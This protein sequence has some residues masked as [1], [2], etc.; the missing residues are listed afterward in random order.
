VQ[1]TAPQLLFVS[2]LNSVRLEVTVEVV[3]VVEVVAVVNITGEVDITT[4]RMAVTTITTSSIK[5]ICRRAARWLPWFS[6]SSRRHNTIR[7][8]TMTLS[9]MRLIGFATKSPSCSAGRCCCA[10]IRSRWRRRRKL[11]LHQDLTDLKETTVPRVPMERQDLQELQANQGPTVLQQREVNATANMALTEKQ[12]CQARKA[13]KERMETYM[14]NWKD[15]QEPRGQWVLLV[16]KVRL[17]QLGHK[18]N[19]AI[20]ER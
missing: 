19:R 17:A 4:D 8:R 1:P 5:R 10:S 18:D 9:M 12:A 16:R 14:R 20:R 13:F 6:E 7:T 2:P 3:T 11:K 15:Y